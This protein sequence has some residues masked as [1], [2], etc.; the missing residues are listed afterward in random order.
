MRV[1]V[2]FPWL[3]Q[4]VWKLLHP[5]HVLRASCTCLSQVRTGDWN[6]QDLNLARTPSVPCIHTF[7]R[8]HPNPLSSLTTLHSNSLPDSNFQTPARPL[9]A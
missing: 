5:D 9:H 1:R 7:P 2:G 8:L 4:A 3:S 6:S